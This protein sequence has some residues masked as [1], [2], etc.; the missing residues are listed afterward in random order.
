MELDD[1]LKSFEESLSYALMEIEEW[2][3]R[4]E[5]AGIWE[6]TDKQ[7]VPADDDRGD[8]CEHFLFVFEQ[9]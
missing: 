3:E 8:D 2:D 4:I 6:I 9:S 5:A 7:N 1:G